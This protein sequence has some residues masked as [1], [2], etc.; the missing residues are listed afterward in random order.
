[1]KKILLSTVA[2][3]SILS[4]PHSCQAASPVTYSDDY[5][6]FEY[7][8]AYNCEISYYSSDNDMTYFCLTSMTED[9]PYNINAMIKII[10]IKDYESQV[11]IEPGT[12]KEYIFSDDSNENYTRKLISNN[13]FPEVEFTYTDDSNKI[14]HTKLIGYNE[15]SF[16]IANYVSNKSLPKL[17]GLC[18]TIYNTVSVS[19]NYIKNGFSADDDNIHGTIFSNVILSS[20]A[21]SYANAAIDIL[22]QYLSFELDAY[23]ASKQIENI[24]TRADDYGESSNYIYDSRVASYLY[25]TALN[26]DNGSDSS[27]I[28]TIEELK[29]LL[30]EK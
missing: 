14:A 16:V 12:W 24:Q 7:T 19:D 29:T 4:C 17:S 2:L 21:Q 11:E 15:N 10:N 18:E 28:E 8:T 1:M 25:S 5:I 30:N 6:S 13:E 3:V 27:I 20:Q 22:K 26:I 23:S 9:D